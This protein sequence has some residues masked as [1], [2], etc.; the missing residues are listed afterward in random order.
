MRGA[1]DSANAAIRQL[2][3]AFAA[4]HADV[5]LVLFP[6]T[7]LQRSWV[8]NYK[9]LGFVNAADGCT[10]DLTFTQYAVGNLYSLAD[11][12][13]TA[14]AAQARPSFHPYCMHP[15]ALGPAVIRLTCIL[16]GWPWWA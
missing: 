15:R 10:S 16:P 5:Q 11:P 2:S 7:A 8:A 12:T 14:G 4:A 1:Q 3:A 9:K 13:F 6:A